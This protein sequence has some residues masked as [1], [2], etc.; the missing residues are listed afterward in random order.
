MAACIDVKQ[1]QN[2]RLQKNKQGN[3]YQQVGVANVGCWVGAACACRQTLIL[4]GPLSM[5]SFP[6]IFV[7]PVRLGEQDDAPGFRVNP[8][9]STGQPIADDVPGFRVSP[10][11]ST[12]SDQAV[13]VPV[14]LKPRVPLPNAASNPGHSLHPPGKWRQF[15]PGFPWEWVPDLPP[16]PPPPQF[17]PPHFLPYQPLRPEPWSPEPRPDHPGRY[18]RQPNNRR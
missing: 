13:P 15:A 17:V 3:I 6:W 10:D 11:G 16:A 7:P 18:G 1:S 4:Q 8:D 2:W 9:G 12:R 14:S 5:P